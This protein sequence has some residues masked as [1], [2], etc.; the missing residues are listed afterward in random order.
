MPPNYQ[1]ADLWKS[2]KWSLSY[3]HK[4]CKYLSFSKIDQI[5]IQRNTNLLNFHSADYTHATQMQMVSELFHTGDTDFVSDFVS[6]YFAFC[7]RAE[8]TSCLHFSHFV[9]NSQ[10]IL[11]DMYCQCCWIYTAKHLGSNLNIISFTVKMVFNTI[12]GILV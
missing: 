8:N 7:T 4:N 9:L 10:K 5:S 11:L 3:T 12:N 2:T 1:S 6:D